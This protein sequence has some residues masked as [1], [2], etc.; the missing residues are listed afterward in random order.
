MTSFEKVDRHVLTMLVDNVPGVTARVVGLFAGRGYNI[1]TICGA[2]THDPKVSR[3][4]ISTWANPDQLEMIMKQ[5]R[6]LVNVIKLA[7]M[8]GRV[9]VRREI[10]LLFVKASPKNRPEIARIMDSFRGKIVD[11]GKSHFIVEATGSEEKINALVRILKPFGIKKTARSGELAL[12]R[13][14][15]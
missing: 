6:R 4:T 7:H 3:I 10:V 15:E 8:T 2:P 9:A 1:E 11:Y 14:I 12:F 5:I 13:D